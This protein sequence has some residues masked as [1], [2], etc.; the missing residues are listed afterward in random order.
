METATHERNLYSHTVSNVMSGLSANSNI[1]YARI[2]ISAQALKSI[3]FYHGK[4]N[5]TAAIKTMIKKT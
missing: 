1:E 2:A 3:A 5:S 4:K